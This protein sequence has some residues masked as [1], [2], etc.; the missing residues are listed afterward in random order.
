MNTF[1]NL[2]IYSVSLIALFSLTAIS[3]E[4]L[5]EEVTIDVPTDVTKTF[6][7]SSTET[8]AFEI[9]EQ[10]DVASDEID[11]RREQMKDFTVESFNFAV[12]DNLAGGS[13]IPT[14][15]Q[16]MF[17]AGDTRVSTG[18][19]VLSGS[20]FEEQLNSLDPEYIRQLKEVVEV[21]VLDDGSLMNIT[22]NGDADAPMDYTITFTMEATIEATVQ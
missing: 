7:I 1:K 21:Y 10:V 11:E 18:A 22:L 4:D 5:S 19:G 14:N 17:D 3:C 8:G 13:G 12:V 15:L 2:L 9:V 16:L 20:T 6:R